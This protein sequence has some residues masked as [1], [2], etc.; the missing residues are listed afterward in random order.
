[1]EMMSLSLQFSCKT[2]FPNRGGCFNLTPFS[3]LSSSSWGKASRGLS[4][5]NASADFSRKRQ[6]KKGKSKGSSQ[7]GFVPKSSIG[8][9]SKKNARVVKKGEQ[10]LDVNVEDDKDGEVELPLEEKLV[11]LDNKTN[12]IAREFG[13]LSLRDE[14]LAVVE[15][16]RGDEIET[17]LL[18]MRMLMMSNYTR[19]KILTSEMIA[20]LR[21]Q[22]L[23]LMIE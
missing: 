1:M 20:V 9:S 15:S 13:E 21:K 22:V 6:H 12:E 16:I 14:T 4:C 5:V 18:L 11:V 19:R 8:S 17:L 3:G 10:T 7:K 23:L 2:F